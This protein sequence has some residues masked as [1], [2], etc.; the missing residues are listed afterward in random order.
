MLRLGGVL[1]PPQFKRVVE[2]LAALPRSG[3]LERLAEKLTQGCQFA[4]L[5]CKFVA[6]CPVL[7]LKA[8]LFDLK[9]DFAITCYCVS[10]SDNRLESTHQLSRVPAETFAT[11]VG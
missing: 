3:V 1:A 6:T 5:C 11:P 10:Y 9:N 2:Q 8:E 4:K 7:G